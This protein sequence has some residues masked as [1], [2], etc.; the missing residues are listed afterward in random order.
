MRPIAT[1]VIRSVVCLSVCLTVCLSGT[2][3]SPVKTPEPIEMPFVWLT[4]VG[5]RNHVLDAAENPFSE[6][7]HFGGSLAH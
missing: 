2:R 5:L 1:D 3:V 6:R 4:R 7:V